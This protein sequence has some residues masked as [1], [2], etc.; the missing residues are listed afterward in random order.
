MTSPKKSGP[1]AEPSLDPVKALYVI[2]LGIND[3]GRT[4]ADELEDLVENPFNDGLDEL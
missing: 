4:D 1:Q 3:C 2:W